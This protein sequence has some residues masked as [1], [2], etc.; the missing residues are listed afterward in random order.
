MSSILGSSSESHQLQNS[1]TDVPA[2]KIVNLCNVRIIITS[3]LFFPSVLLIC[4]YCGYN[5]VMNE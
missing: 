5:N 1:P 3:Q 2:T 4:F